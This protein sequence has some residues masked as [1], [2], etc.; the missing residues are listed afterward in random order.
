MGSTKK[1]ASQQTR[2]IR[3][4]QVQETLSAWQ[5]QRQ[6]AAVQLQ[7]YRQQ[8]WQA[9]QATTQDW[10]IE[11]QQQR[12]VSGP[13]IQQRLAEYGRVRSQNSQVLR[14]NLSA[15]VGD[16]Q[17]DVGMAL[18]AIAQKRQEQAL[19]LRQRLAADRQ[20]P[21]AAIQTLFSALAI[22]RNERVAYRQALT[23]QVWGTAPALSSTALDRD[24]YAVPQARVSSPL[25][26][27]AA[28]TPLDLSAISSKAVEEAVYQYLQ[29]QNQARLGEIESAL[30]INRLQTVDALRSLMQK[31][32]I[33]R[34]DRSYQLAEVIL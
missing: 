27:A 14:S 22:S 3:Q 31:Q 33:V 16:L 23:H 11:I 4:Q 19:A 21:I 7:H 25:R 6:S 18:C 1:T 15:L 24:S 2:L 29:T 5:Q 12:Q 26:A 9:Q 13:K 32:L 17:V 10:L 30:K 28:T 8:N 20:K 34:R